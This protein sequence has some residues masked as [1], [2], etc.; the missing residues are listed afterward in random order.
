[1]ESKLDI[2]SIGEV[3][4]ELSAD[5]KLVF[6]DTL[7][8][9]YGGDCMATAI[10]AQ[11]AGSKVG[12]IT[13]VG[14][15][16]FK[17]FLLDAWQC[18]GLDISQVKLA[19]E[20]NG[21]YIIAMPSNEEKEIIYYR[22]KIAP[23]KLT[24]DD[25]SEKYISSAKY[26]YSSGITQSLSASASEVVSYAFKTAQ[27]NGVSTAYTPSF[28]PNVTSVDIAK[29]Y[30]SNVVNNLDILFMEMEFD[31]I[32]LIGL[33]SPDSVIKKMWDYGIKI[34]II[35]SN[36]NKKYYV[37][38][39]GNVTEYSFYD[40]GIVDTTSSFDAFNGGFLSAMAN[41]MTPYDSVKFASVMEGIQV[42][43]IGAIKSIPFKA[44]VIN[45]L[46]GEGND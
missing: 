13:K 16:A 34:V 14:N 38:Y 17:E 4:V 30:L 19:E 9:Y 36:Q 27:K 2:I 26:V 37:G 18:E 29:E 33:Y 31:V 20:K 23:S 41:G 35:K 25:I 21:L 3:L 5:C 42:A 43:N 11:R 10:A 28:N 6:A 1:M 45:I 40:I 24:I 22:K 15:D 39:N 46:K 32:P 8:K 7:N 12:F 44:D